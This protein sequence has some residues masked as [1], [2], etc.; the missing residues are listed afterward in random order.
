MVTVKFVKSNFP[1]DIQKIIAKMPDMVERAMKASATEV[2]RNLERVTE[3]WGDKPKFEIHMYK[4][5]VE[6]T[7][8]DAVFHYLNEGTPAHEI[9]PK[10]RRGRRKRA[11]TLAFLWTGAG[12]E[13]NA[14]TKPWSFSSDHS[15]FN[16]S[17][18]TYFFQ[19][20]QHPGIEPRKWDQILRIEYENDA[21]ERVQEEL[22]YG[23]QAAGL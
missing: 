18:T 5:K 10:A 6:V 17:P 20:V 23:L 19:A 4:N 2:V 22:D 1:K 3:T 11:K 12:G 14:K 9:V 16:G 15:Y 7:T 13:Y 21:S 8:E